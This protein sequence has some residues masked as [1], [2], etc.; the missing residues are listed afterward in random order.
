MA[1]RS[2]TATAG[3]WRTPFGTWATTR[4]DSRHAMTLSLGF[5]PCPNDCFMFDAIVHGRIDL[6]GLDFYVRLADVEALNTAAFAGETD[7][8]KLSFHA[9]AHCTGSYV[10]LDAGSALGRKCGPLLI[11][12][13]SISTG[14]SPS[15]RLRIAIPG[16]TRPPTSSSGW[17]F[18]PRRT[19]RTC[20]SRR[21]SRRSR[22]E[23]LRR[24]ADHSREPLHLRAE[25]APE[26]HRSRGVLGGR[27]GGADSARGHRHTARTS[28]GRQAAVNRLVRR[29]VEYAFANPRPACPL[30]G[31][32]AGDERGRHVPAHRPLCERLF[33][34]SR[35]E[36]RR[37]VEVPVRA[38]PGDRH[39]AR[40]GGA[41][42][43]ATIAPRIN[44]AVHSGC[45]RRIASRGTRAAL[46]G[47]RLPPS[48]AGF[49][50]AHSR[51][52]RRSSSAR[53]SATAG[54]LWESCCARRWSST[55]PPRTPPCA[56]RR[57]RSRRRRT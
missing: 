34:G 28:R 20:C 41:V 38:R 24:R 25:R 9:Y 42:V 45:A 17:R 48:G 31:T 26:D 8:T 13:R 22:R 15:G 49:M 27:D 18:R 29:S 39:S 6:E 30:S 2:E 57:P 40:D 19:R 43:P 1:W 21:S 50:P 37:A 51:R 54:P 11:S 53:S 12:R 47:S 32:R 4:R 7:V 14:M 3:G 52:R 5:S 35:S 46:R 16:T 55:W 36:G 56:R 23:R 33:P 10:F 44:A